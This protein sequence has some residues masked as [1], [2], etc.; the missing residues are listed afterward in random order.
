M[1]RIGLACIFF[2]RH[3]LRTVLHLSRMSVGWL[4]KLTGQ[5][6][7]L[8]GGYR[9]PEPKVGEVFDIQDEV[10]EAVVYRNPRSG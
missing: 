5:N 2:N 9:V 7:G 1:L 4:G 3:A 6:R 10:E 8:E